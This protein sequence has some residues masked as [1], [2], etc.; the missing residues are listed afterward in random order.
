MTCAHSPAGSTGV[1]AFLRRYRDRAAIAVATR[2]S[3]H[4]VEDA[5]PTVPGGVWKDTVVVLPDGLNTAWKDAFTGKRIE[6]ESS[7]LRLTGV[8][9]VL[10]VAMLAVA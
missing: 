10:P 2:L 7:R 6:S 9:W 8:L 5:C 3:A 1:I 4:I